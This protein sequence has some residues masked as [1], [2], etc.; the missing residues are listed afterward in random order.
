MYEL[1]QAWWPLAKITVVYTAVVL[2]I[3]AHVSMILSASYFCWENRLTKIKPHTIYSA[4]ICAT[5]GLYVLLLCDWI[6]DWPK[7]AGSVWAELAWAWIGI[8]W[9]HAGYRAIFGPRCR[10]CALLIDFVRGKKNG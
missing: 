9:A 3:L 1:L 2:A 7:P 8:L 10:S 5:S 4:L 6:G